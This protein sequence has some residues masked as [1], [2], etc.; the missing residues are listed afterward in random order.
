[1]RLFP[2]V[3]LLAALVLTA[4]TSTPA[5][6]DISPALVS[7]LVN[8]NNQSSYHITLAV[9]SMGGTS[10]GDIVKPDKMRMTMPTGASV[11]IGSVMYLEMNGKWQKM[12]GGGDWFAKMNAAKMM[13]LHRGDYAS[14]DLGMRTI[15]GGAGIYHA[16]QLTDTKK[17]LS[18]TIYIDSSNRIAR[19]E[20]P[21]MVITFSNFGE[22]VN[23]HAPM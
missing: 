19:M 4:A 15:S 17:N 9:K 7:A 20:M 5:S 10:Q 21:D 2:I 11:V 1:M 8:T 18:Q 13:N 22:H 14:K 16:Y 23:I 12:A 3:G 6:A